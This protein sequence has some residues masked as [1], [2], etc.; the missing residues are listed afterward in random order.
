M[1]VLTR[2]FGTSAAVAEISPLPLNGIPVP[3]LLFVQFI[4]APGE[5]TVNDIL[6]GSFPHTVKLGIGSRMGTGLMVMVK[7]IGWPVQMPAMG[8]TVMLAVCG[9]TTVAPVKAMF[10]TPLGASPIPGL[11]FVQLKVVPA[12]PVRLTVTN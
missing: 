6:I 11:S 10:P 4:V 5:E 7:L 3:V 2:T 1:I 9:L 12:E 8:I